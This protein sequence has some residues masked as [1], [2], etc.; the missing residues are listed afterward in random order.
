MN[1]RELLINFSVQLVV[2]VS[3]ADLRTITSTCSFSS[4]ISCWKQITSHTAVLQA[5][6]SDQFWVLLY[7]WNNEYRLQAQELVGWFSIIWY[8]WSWCIL[9]GSDHMFGSRS[10]IKCFLPF[11]VCKIMILSYIF[12]SVDYGGSETCRSTNIDWIW[13]TGYCQTLE[14]SK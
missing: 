7:H 12:F 10:T 2:I 14:V 6:S 9:I 11:I 8:Q 5:H 1:K 4:V 13:G 3:G